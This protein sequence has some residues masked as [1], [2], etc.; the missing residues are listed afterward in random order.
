[1]TLPELLLIL[2]SN[3]AFIVHCCRSNRGGEINP[4]P[5]YPN[6]LKATIGD[7]A[8]GGGRSVSCSVVW[9]A[10]QHTFGEIGIIVKPRDVG[11]VVRVSTGDAGT[12]ENG[13]GFGE[14]L[15]HAS[16]GRTFTQ[17]TDHNEWVLTGGDVVGIFL[18]FETGLYVAQMREAPPGMSLEEAKVLGIPPAPYPVKVTVANV[19]ADFPGLP[20]F[21]FVAGVLTQIAAGHPY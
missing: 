17:S 9:P 19:A 1:M 18:N 8:A 5:L 3:D 6:D 4:K 10:H 15:S 14:P 13:E 7:L 12:L 11:E 16:V 20:L 2:K 21:G